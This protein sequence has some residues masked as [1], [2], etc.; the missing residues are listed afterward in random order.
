MTAILLRK[1]P[2]FDFLNRRAGIDFDEFVRTHAKYRH[3]IEF[4]QFALPFDYGDA[5]LEY[6]AIRNSCAMFDASSSRKYRIRGGRAGDFLDHLLTRPVSLSPTMRASY[7]VFCNPD[8]TLKDDAIVYKYAQ[9]DYL[10]MPALTHDEYFEELRGRF[11]SAVSI[12][13]CSDS[14][15]GISLQGPLSTTVLHSW[16]LDGIEELKPFEVREYALGGGRMRISRMGF[17]ADLGYECWFDP[18]LCTAFQ[19]GIT[20][21][22]RRLGIEIPGYGLTAVEVC[23]LE[24]GLIVPGRD[25]AIELAPQPG[26]ERS[27]FELGLGWLVKFDGR[28]FV[29]NRALQAERDQGSRFALLSFE[30]DSPCKPGRQAKLYAA[31]DGADRD[32]GVLTS[33]SWSWGLQRTI[34]LASVERRYADCP[35]GYMRLGE[36]DER[37]AVDLKRGPL[38]NLPRRTQLPAPIGVT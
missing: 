2:F 32:V 1:G 8:G 33:S 23:R 26:F 6:R 35:R 9:D 12:T 25:C 29:G 15:A 11:G 16:G 21:A 13:Q 10:L 36:S 4:H 38:I 22:A 31:I 28:E 18:A 24:G 30:I 19:E 37:V 17:T 27:P 5:E 7:A 20:S 14:V 3:Y 34:G